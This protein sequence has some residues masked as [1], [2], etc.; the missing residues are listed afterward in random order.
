[1]PNVELY[2]I[3][4]KRRDSVS[5]CESLFDELATRATR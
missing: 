1:M 3:A 4:R 5:L 2:R